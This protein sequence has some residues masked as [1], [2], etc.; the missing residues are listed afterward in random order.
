VNRPADR[1]RPAVPPPGV[2]TVGPSGGVVWLEP[3]PPPGPRCPRCGRPVHRL[4]VGD[5]A[6]LAVVLL[7]GKGWDLVPHRC[8]PLGAA[9]EYRPHDQ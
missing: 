7:G 6:D 5:G 9:G 3:A 4:P 8:L 1:F 2:W